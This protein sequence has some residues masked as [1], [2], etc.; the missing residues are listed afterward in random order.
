MAEEA[1]I[2]LD[3]EVEEQF[4]LVGATGCAFGWL[5]GWLVGSVLRC[6]VL[7]C[8]FAFCYNARSICNQGK[9]RNQ[10]AINEKKRRM[11]ILRRELKSML[12]GLI[13]DTL[14]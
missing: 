1:D 11:K 5:V 6:G 4:G 13:I 3:E 14:T 7:C 12:S 8:R 2:C 10:E 9:H